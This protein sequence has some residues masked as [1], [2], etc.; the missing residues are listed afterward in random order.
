MTTEPTHDIATLQ[1]ATTALRATPGIVVNL[2][3]RTALARHPGYVR[4]D[5]QTLGKPVPDRA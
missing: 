4:I 2:R 5:R 3:D 1:S